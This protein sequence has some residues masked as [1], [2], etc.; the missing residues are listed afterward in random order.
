MATP[1]GNRQKDVFRGLPCRFQPYRAN[2][3]E[4]DE[5]PP[6]SALRFISATPNSCRSRLGGSQ[7]SVLPTIEQ[8]PSRGPSK[9]IRP[10]RNVSLSATQPDG[11]PPPVMTP[12]KPTHPTKPPATMNTNHGVSL[13]TGSK[14]N[15]FFQIHE[16]LHNELEDTPIKK[17]TTMP[18]NTYSKPTPLVAGDENVRSIYENLG[19]EDEVDEAM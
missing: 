15:P 4:V 3:P 14:P 12:T 6:S 1:K 13:G 19:W 7:K 10:C 9:H 2:L 17:G 18:A 5:V 8:T 11:L 16:G